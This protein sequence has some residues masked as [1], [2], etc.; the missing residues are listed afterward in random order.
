MSLFTDDLKLKQ[1]HDS[2]G[3]NRKKGL[4]RKA[5]TSKLQR[6]RLMQNRKGMDPVMKCMRNCN[7]IMAQCP[8]FVRHQRRRD[9]DR[10]QGWG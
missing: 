2:Q 6:V 1:M 8:H 9:H 4:H 10:R 3:S 7:A 5:Y